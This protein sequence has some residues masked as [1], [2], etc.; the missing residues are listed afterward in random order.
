MPQG[1]AENG[2]IR[3]NRIFLQKKTIAASVKKFFVQ[4]NLL[5]K[6]EMKNEKKM[7]KE[8]M[9]KPTQKFRPAACALFF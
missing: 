5:R 4:K 8:K 9:R 1:I 2:E 6:D 7:R 3:I